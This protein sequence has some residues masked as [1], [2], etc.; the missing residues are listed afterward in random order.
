MHEVS[1]LGYIVGNQGL[2]VD[3]TKTAALDSW[4]SPS[5]NTEVRSF[6]GLT[7][8]YRRFIRNFSTLARSISD[9]LKKEIFIW[10]DEAEKAFCVSK[11]KLQQAPVLALPDFSKFFEIECDASIIGV[12]VVLSQGGHPISFLSE[13]LSMDRSFIPLLGLLQG[14]G[15]LPTS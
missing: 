10:T 15:T 2:K 1:F 5:N 9:C 11:E 6:L 12:G 4:M 3:S 8:F 7:S 13:K 14:M